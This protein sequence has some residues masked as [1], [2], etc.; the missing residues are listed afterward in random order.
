[1]EVIR[2]DIK[3]VEEIQEF[4]A[5]HSKLKEPELLLDL[6]YPITW[7]EPRVDLRE[8]AKLRFEDGWS[9]KQLAEYYGKTE[10]AIQSYFQKIKRDGIT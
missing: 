8:L 5:R 9:R 1:M 4:G 6:I 2:K 10:W 3:R 7:K